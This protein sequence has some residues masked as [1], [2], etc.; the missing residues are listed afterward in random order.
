MADD[1]FWDPKTDNTGKWYASTYPGGGVSGL[2][3]E[4]S[5]KTGGAL[6]AVSFVAEQ[7]NPS[8]TIF[9]TIT[10]PPIY[11]DSRRFQSHPGGPKLRVPGSHYRV[12]G[13][14]RPPV[15]AST[16]G[17]SNLPLRVI[18]SAVKMPTNFCYQPKDLT[19]PMDQGNCGS[20]WAFS[21]CHM[22]ADRVAIMTKGKIKVPLSTRQVMECGDYMNGVSSVGCEGNDPYT[23]IKSIEDKPINI[24]A[25]DAYQ[26]QYDQ[27]NT[28]PSA[29]IVVDPSD[30]YSVSCKSSFMISESIGKPGDAANKRNIENMKQH[31]YNEGPVLC[32]FTCYKEFA[33]YDGKTIYEPSAD[34]DA[35]GAGGHAIEIIGWGKE[36][37]S[38]VSYWIGRNSWGPNWPADHHKC[39]GIS[40]FYIRMGSNVCKI[41]E[42]ACGATPIVHNASKAPKSGRQEDGSFPGSVVCHAKDL[43]DVAEGLTG[44]N[45]FFE[46]KPYHIVVPLLVIGAA[47]IGWKNRVQIAAKFSSLT[48]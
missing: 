25:R 27:G 7:T 8:K 14:K 13:I 21:L 46:I 18:K 39:A 4:G 37:A 11:H 48:K 23:V 42:Y 47:Y 15:L 30:G 1:A 41:E 26:H 16:T 10:H 5:A 36:P 22:L 44:V 9:T 20:C 12:T 35:E 28:D 2:E 40:F 6:A 45:R 29:C 31:I 3:E 38:G 32:T 17:K 43:A 33:D 34:V 19:R 24:R